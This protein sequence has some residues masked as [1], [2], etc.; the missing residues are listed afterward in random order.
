MSDLDRTPVAGERQTYS[1]RFIHAEIYRVRAD[2]N[3][4][5]HSHSPAVIPFSVT[6]VALRTC[7]KRRAR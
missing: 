2:V 5:V 6:D 3:A 1:E 7:P 4:V